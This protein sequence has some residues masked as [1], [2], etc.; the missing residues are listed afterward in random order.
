MGATVTRNGKTYYKGDD[1]KLYSD[2]NAARVAAEDRRNAGVLQGLQDFFKRD[3]QSGYVG[4]VF[5]DP[6][7]GLSGLSADPRVHNKPLSEDQLEALSKG[8]N[9]AITAYGSVPGVALS[10]GPGSGA[11]DPYGD[12]AARARESEQRRMMQQYASKEYWDTEQGKA[13]LSLG[14][15]MT[16]PKDA[17]LAD[18]YS[19]Q[20]AAGTG[21][22]SE[23]LEGLAS[24]DDRYKE[25]GDLR[26]WAEANQGLALRE[27]NKRFP[28]GFSNDEAIG[29]LPRDYENNYATYQAHQAAQEGVD[30]FLAAQQARGQEAFRDLA[31]YPLTEPGGNVQP[32]AVASGAYVP[33]TLVAGLNADGQRTVGEGAY[34]FDPAFDEPL[35]I[36]Q[37]PA[38]PPVARQSNLAP[39][40]AVAQQQ[41]QLADELVN[42][43]RSRTRGQLLSGT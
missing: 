39:V 42:R 27:Y 17:K 6:R 28:G 34:G 8:Q 41:Q 37:S 24:V 38:P 11:P 20:R 2:Y 9:E 26:K 29:A 40:T 15:Q 10:P 25:G 18:Y 7:R 30:A 33:D 22:M 16:A 4:A 43:Y 31:K 21:A 3:R 12:P 19:A 13:M 36:A 32:S 23:I 5:P 14:Q 35:P 1:G